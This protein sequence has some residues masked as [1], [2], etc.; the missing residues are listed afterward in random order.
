MT[1]GTGESNRQH[2]S[3]LSQGNIRFAAL[4]DPLLKLGSVIAL[5]ADRYSGL[6]FADAYESSAHESLLYLS[7]QL[8]ALKG[9]LGNLG[10]YQ[11]LSFLMDHITQN[12]RESLS[13]SGYSP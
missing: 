2:A 5:A 1:P 6:P 10:A 9:P 3:I 8:Q 7:E 12:S 13:P 11:D 4:N